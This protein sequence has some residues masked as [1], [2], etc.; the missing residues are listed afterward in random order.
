[1]S[2]SD[3]LRSLPVFEKARRRLDARDTELLRKGVDVSLTSPAPS[4]AFKSVFV[5]FS[6]GLSFVFGFNLLMLCE[7]SL[8]TLPLLLPA[9]ALLALSLWLAMYT[10]LFGSRFVPC[11][12]TVRN[13]E[14]FLYANKLYVSRET[15]LSNGTK[16]ELSTRRSVSASSLAATC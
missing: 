4:G 6:A 7:R 13:L 11:G 3:S 9:V 2:F 1:M 5:L 12:S 16:R 10:A 8:F 15:T 14:R